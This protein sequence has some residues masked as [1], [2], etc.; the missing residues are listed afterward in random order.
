MYIHLI[1]M[2]VINFSSLFPPQLV[3][4]AFH[5]ERLRPLGHVIQ[6][7]VRQELHQWQGRDVVKVY[8]A[9]KTI[10]FR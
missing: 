7:I 3:L 9:L 2:H 1:E 8:D 5:T 6:A 4:K 10:T